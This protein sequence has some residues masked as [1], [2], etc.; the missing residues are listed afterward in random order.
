MKLSKSGYARH[1]QCSESTV[2]KAL[3][4]QRITLGDDGLI[5]VEAADKAWEAGTDSARLRSPPDGSYLQA[6]IEHER[7]KDALARLKL[8][9]QSGEVVNRKIA[10]DVVFGLARAERDSWQGWPQRIAALMGAELGVDP[11]TMETV[12][13]R[14]VREHLVS[15]SEFHIDLMKARTK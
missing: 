15:M 3:K 5:D 6:R 7:T 10:E 9:K 1:R 8:R 4:T 11:H 12:L 14:Y 2:R 13:N